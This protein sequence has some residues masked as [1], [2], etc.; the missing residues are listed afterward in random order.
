M[1]NLYGNSNSYWHTYRGDDVR[2]TQA[3]GRVARVSGAVEGS[4]AESG[5]GLS[6]GFGSHVGFVTGRSEGSGQMNPGNSWGEHGDCLG[7][8]TPRGRGDPHFKR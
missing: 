7:E 3:F 5:Q 8:V 1:K 6:L 4:L 2:E